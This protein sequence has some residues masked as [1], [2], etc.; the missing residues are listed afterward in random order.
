MKKLLGF[1][2]I[3]LWAISSSWAQK[4]SITDV[5]GN[6]LY[7][8]ERIV[9]HASDNPRKAIVTFYFKN[10]IEQRAIT[11]RQEKLVS[12]LEWVK[13]GKS[14]VKKEKIVE[15]I[16]ANLKPGE[17]IEWKLQIQYNT[18]KR[19]AIV[20][21]AALLL[22]NEQFEVIKIVFDEVLLPR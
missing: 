2:M 17:E 5:A 22:M 3:V 19:M 18:K 7:Q 16:T 1:L 9:E 8:Y 20:E 14:V 12:K 15:K 10:G 11:Y 6:L 13:K 4:D 21:K